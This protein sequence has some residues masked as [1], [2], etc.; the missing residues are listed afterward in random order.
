MQREL[1]E[2]RAGPQLQEEDAE[3]AELRVSWEQAEA[4]Y[5]RALQAPQRVEWL[6][7]FNKTLSAAEAAEAA[8]RAAQKRKMAPIIA[9]L[10]EAEAALDASRSE[11]FEGE[12][13]AY[14]DAYRLWDEANA[15]T[16][17]HA[18]DGAAAGLKAAQKACYAQAW[19]FRFGW[20]EAQYDRDRDAIRRERCGCVCDDHCCEW[21]SDD[22]VDCRKCLVGRKRPRSELSGYVSD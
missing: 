18:Y 13:R 1:E 12:R 8:W 3:D 16:M 22:Q 17:A 15:T 21:Y 11:G 19:A 5:L 2:E 7:H 6:D 14:D 9:A 20:C 10:E 4:A